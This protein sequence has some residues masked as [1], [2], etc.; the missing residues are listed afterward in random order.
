MRR[1]PLD[2]SLFSDAAMPKSTSGRFIQRRVK[3]ISSSILHLES[4]KIIVLMNSNSMERNA[5][6]WIDLESWV[7]CIGRCGLE[8]MYIEW[9]CRRLC[10]RQR[11]EE[12]EAVNAVLV[13]RDWVAAVLIWLI[14]YMEGLFG[15]SVQ[16]IR[17]C[18]KV[19]GILRRFPP[20]GRNWRYEGTWTLKDF[21][22]L[23]E[24]QRCRIPA[25]RE[26]CL[27]TYFRRRQTIRC[28][29]SAAR[30][31]KANNLNDQSRSSIIALNLTP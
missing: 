6:Q 16:R 14:E 12:F 21:I 24:L 13:T 29:A 3:P 17:V 11:L 30:H 27:P 15:E 23:A 2:S 31:N 20:V 8:I 28:S 10:G 19:L 22:W 5:S 1:Y 26:P 7:W 9:N 4:K 25:T 18:L